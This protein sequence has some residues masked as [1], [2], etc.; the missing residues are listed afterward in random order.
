LLSICPFSSAI[1][2]FFCRNKLSW[3]A[4][5]PVGV[6]SKSFYKWL[7]VGRSFFSPSDPHLRLYYRDTERQRPTLMSPSGVRTLGLAVGRS[8]LIRFFFFKSP[9][10]VFPPGQKTRS[11]LED[12]Q[13]LFPFLS[14]ILRSFRASFFILP[15]Q[16]APG[17]LL[18][19]TFSFFQATPPPSVP[20]P[21]TLAF[22]MRAKSGLPSSPSVLSAGS[23]SDTPPFSSQSASFM[24]SPLPLTFWV[25][26]HHLANKEHTP[27]TSPYIFPPFSNYHFLIFPPY[28]AVSVLVFRGFPLILAPSDLVR[29]WRGSARVPIVPFSFFAVPSLFQEILSVIARHTLFST[30]TSECHSFS[31]IYFSL[32]E[33]NGDRS[34]SF[35]LF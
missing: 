13:S 26:L 14:Q 25:P 3:F 11:P 31:L 27:L 32:L 23:P 2:L 21:L 33:E 10:F 17:F 20:H 12:C 8:P 1:P 22:Q 7:S 18:R 16:A 19:A 5:F 34:F 4:V 6:R 9:D 15:R 35:A 29:G 28:L 30:G 24:R